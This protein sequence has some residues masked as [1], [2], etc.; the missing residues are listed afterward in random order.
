MGIP[1]A[2]I[3]YAQNIFQARLGQDYGYGGSWSRTNLSALTDCSGL[4][5]EELEAVTKGANMVWGHP[6]S[7]ESWPYDYDN[8]LPAQPGTVGPYGTVAVASPNDF[9]ADAAVTIAI[10]HGG[11]GV[12]SHMNCCVA[13][14][15]M[16]DNG[17][18]GVCTT[19]VAMVQT[20]PY[21]TDWWYL[22]GPIDGSVVTQPDPDANASPQ[23]IADKMDGQVNGQPLPYDLVDL[24]RKSKIFSL[25]NGD[26]PYPEGE[27][28]SPSFIDHANT[29]A[30]VIARTYVAS[31]GRE[32]D[33]WDAVMTILKWVLIQDAT[34]NANETA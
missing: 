7:T 29:D 19:P 31:D 28:V 15:L 23:S 8:N 16:E 17:D 2:N 3:T 1:A 18:D 9:P 6:V 32:Y 13:G 33:L 5:G 10:H 20:D 30:K 4:V 11:G 26:Y 21:W 14:M 34:V 24:L 12:D 25:R 27:N 22:P